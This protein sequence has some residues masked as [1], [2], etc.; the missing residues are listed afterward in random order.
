MERIRTALT[1]LL[2]RP[3]G[4]VSVPRLIGAIALGSALAFAGISHLTVARQEFQA[5]VPPWFPVDKDAVVLASGVLEVALGAALIALRK[6]RVPVGL[7][8]A[9]FFILIFPGNISQYATR[10]DAFGLDTDRDRLVRLLFQPV[11]VAWAL[12]CTGAWKE[13]RA[14]LRSD[15]KRP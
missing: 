15:A 4:K 8:A 12:W 11:L 5:Q 2:T 1:H 14:S 9:A 6:R 7:L 3:A 10:T 13:L